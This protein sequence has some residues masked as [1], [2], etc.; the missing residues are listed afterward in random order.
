MELRILGDLGD[1][2][3]RCD[4][5]VGLGERGHPLVA[6]ASRESHRERG[7]D[8]VLAVIVQLVV[9]P[10]LEV[11]QSAE[12]GVERGFDGADGEPATIVALVGVVTRV[13]AGEDVVAG[14]WL[15]TGGEILV[16]GEGHEPEHPIGHRA[17]EVGAVAGALP[18]QE[19]GEDREARRASRRPL[20]RRPWRRAEADLRR[21]GA[22]STRGS[23]TRRGS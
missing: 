19:C 17:V 6:V 11:E 1:G 10:L 14:T 8:L 12:V 7:A 5:R 3:D 16:D 13:A 2:Q 21:P 22:P 9:G 15:D 23:P 18:A 20:R 4:A